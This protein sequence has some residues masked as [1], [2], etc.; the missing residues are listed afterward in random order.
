[1]EK[2][3]AMTMMMRIDSTVVVC[4]ESV[5][6]VLWQRL[7]EVRTDCANQNA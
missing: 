7:K 4:F 6:R 5:W 2:V 1:M 3:G